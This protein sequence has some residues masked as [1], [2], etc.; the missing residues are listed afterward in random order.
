MSDA[1]IHADTRAQASWCRTSWMCSSWY[2]DG[3]TRRSFGMMPAETWSVFSLKNTRCEFADATICGRSVYYSK[4]RWRILNVLASWYLKY[5]C[6]WKVK[7]ARDEM[8]QGTDSVL[9]IYRMG[10]KLVPNVATNTF[11][12]DPDSEST[13]VSSRRIDRNVI[14][15]HNMHK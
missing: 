9:C 6:G 4:R 11:L 10:T 12:F 8:R 7:K 14:F 1:F 2:T 15:F 3:V 5:S 13:F